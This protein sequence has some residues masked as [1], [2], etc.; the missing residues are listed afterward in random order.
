MTGR[1][2]IY[3]LSLL[4]SLN[5]QRQ[6]WNCQDRMTLLTGHRS[7]HDALLDFLNRSEAVRI[8]GS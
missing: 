3:V 7:I 5:A 1:Q 8:V 6:V 2:L 4:E